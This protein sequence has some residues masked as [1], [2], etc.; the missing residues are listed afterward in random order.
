MMPDKARKWFSAALSGGGQP[1]AW[2][3]DVDDTITD[4]RAMHRQA[5]AAV[6]DG[7]SG[8]LS[9]E[10]AR[11]VAGR[12]R[13]VFDEL[14]LVHQQSPASAGDEHG[15]PSDL[16]QRSRD[17]QR[18]IAAKWGVTRL[19]SREILL[20][21]AAEDCGAT[22]TADQLR[23]C[24]DRYWDHMLAHPVLFPD[25]VRLV[26]HIAAHG[27]RPYLMTSSDAR[28][29]RLESGQ[30]SYD[31][32]ESRLDKQHRMENLRRYGI[33]FVDAFIGDPVDKP[34]KEF[35]EMA[36]TRIAED[37]RRPLGSFPVVIVGDSYR[38]D[39]QT[40][41][42]MVDPV[43]GVLYKRE[44]TT[45]EIES[46]AVISVGDFDTFIEGLNVAEGKGTR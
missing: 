21:L 41:M 7:L 15:A 36:L 26:R 45:I 18:E 14:L 34:S 16:E 10:L 31:P 28:Y 2:L 46:D 11:S 1:I 44:Q 37:L 12:F 40:P 17:Y 8:P 39:L 27:G 4:T 9:A 3:L 22:L 30:F 19:F 20:Q 35:F 6:A 5:A 23:R 24:V 43:V 38:S 25:S 32:V 33:D 29:H 42:G 13:E